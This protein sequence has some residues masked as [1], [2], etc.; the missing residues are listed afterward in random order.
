MLGGRG[1]DV[2]GEMCMSSCDITFG[3]LWLFRQSPQSRSF[4]S[5][6]LFKLNKKCFFKQMFWYYL[7]HTNHKQH[8]V[9]K[10]YN[11]NKENTEWS[12]TELNLAARLSTK[13]RHYQY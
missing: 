8:S 13:R 2:I 12:K 5:H 9:I 10:T 4:L 7:A 3:I 11:N 1:I 6:N